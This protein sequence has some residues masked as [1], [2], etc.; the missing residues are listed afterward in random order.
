[1]NDL[2][3][4]DIH[5][6]GAV[7][8]W[9]MAPGWWLLII[10]AGVAA[11]LAVVYWYRRGMRRRALRAFDDIERAYAMHGNARR[12]VTDVSTL[13]RRI[14]LTYHPRTRVA[15]VTGKAW[16]NV[17]RGLT[18]ADRALPD[19]IAWQI[20]HAPY[21]PAETVDADALIA[22]TRRY[23]KALPPLWDGR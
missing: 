12:L 7:S 18:G 5:L 4:R 9:P 19:R 21:N 15:S 6:P 20:V 8:F 2:P 1:M 14:C 13:L 23:L 11:G 10:W 3:L 16:R 22:H 17:L